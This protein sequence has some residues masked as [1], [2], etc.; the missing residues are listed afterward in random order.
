MPD[1]WEYP[2]FAAWDMAFHVIALA[3]ID[4]DFAKDQL[5][6]LMR[7][8]YMHPNGQIPAYEWNFGDVN[9]PVHAWA[10]IRVFQIE[11]KKYGRSDRAFLERVFQKL[12]I[13]FTWWVNRKDSEGNNIFEGGF[14]GLDNIGAFDRSEGLPAGGQLEQA[15]GTS[16]MAMYC[17]NMLGLALELAR[18]D[19]VYEDVATKFFEH[20]VYIGAAI[21]QMGGRAGGLWFDD[22]GFYFDALKLPDDRCYPD[23][24]AHDRRADPG[25]RRRDRRARQR[26]RCSASSRSASAGSPST[27]RSSSSASATSRTAASS[28]AL[29]LALVDTPKLRR[30]LAHVLD[31]DGMLSPYGV[32]SV[33]KRHAARSLRPRARRPALRARLRARRIDDAALRRQFELA[34]PGV[35]SAELP[36]DR[37]AAEAPLLPRRRFQG[38]ACRPVPATTATLWDVTTDLTRRLIGV[39]LRTTHGR[40]PVNGDRREVPGRSAL[41]RPH[42]VPR[43]LPRRQRVGAGREPPDRAGRAIVAKLIQQYGEYALQGRPPILV[44]RDE[45]VS[46]YPA[47]ATVRAPPGG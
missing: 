26:A 37:G 43:I 19:P 9:P 14:L 40:R 45:I 22:D 1:K 23:P 16:W 28:S 29:R 31:E 11:E 35:V 41:A 20:Y 47:S 5:L 25:A 42:P 3:M 46:R 21:N 2:W 39:F 30:I 33:S 6:L 12:L 10:A 24:R 8:W 36:A 18:E 13:N 34:R 17:L 7:E 32:R 15:D 27:G 38:R 4:P 44:E